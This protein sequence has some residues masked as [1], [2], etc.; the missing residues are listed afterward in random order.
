LTALSFPKAGLGVLAWTAL[1]P[2]LFVSGPGVSPRRAAGLGLAAGS[3]FHAVALHWIYFTCRFAGIGPVLAAVALGALSALLALNWAAAA[4]LAQTLGAR[5][6]RTLRPWVWALAWTAV[7]VAAERWTPRV[8]GDLLEYTQWRSLAWVQIAA[9]AGPHA[10][11]FLIVAV[12]GVIAELW[13][14]PEGMEWSAAAA[15]GL[16]LTVLVYGIFS[17]TER[18]LTIRAPS[19][20]IAILQPAIDQYRKWDQQ[21]AD[22]IL[23]G[24]KDLINV[25]SSG[26][27]ELVIWPESA[28]PMI[29][30]EGDT[31]PLVSQLAVSS[32][33]WHLVGAVTRVEESYY[34]SAFL[35]GPE[36]GV[37]GR[38]HKRQ[39][40]PFGEFVPIPWL[41]R[42]IGALNALGDATPGEP[43]QDLFD[44]PLGPAAVTLCYEATFPRWARRD[45]ARG[46]RLIVNL[47]NDGWYKDTWG[48]YQHFYTNMFRAVETRTPVVRAGNN[49]ISGI[50]DPW[51][52][53]LARLDLNARG[54]LDAGLPAGDPFPGG[55]FY[56]RRGDW[57]G[58]LCLGALL[59]L[60]LIKETA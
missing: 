48:P 33:T 19:A 36:G 51:G 28:L 5:L 53:V 7:A 30:D 47:T 39:L 40:V 35:V 14:E 13:R 38:Y 12:N 10:L 15:A 52:G 49:G 20:R 60:L 31:V 34:S 50:I 42:F 3:A 43:D 2:W 4:W 37:H 24:Y 45:V 56:A 59:L 8:A 18:S 57:F 46:A 22:E 6:H 17:L 41:R 25:P 1:A 58:T 44:T 16:G 55:S 54:R 32:G 21:F 29:V 9:I 11:G 26:K 27:P 23:Q